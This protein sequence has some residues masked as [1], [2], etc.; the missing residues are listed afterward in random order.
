[1]GG[2]APINVRILIST[3]GA[4]QA[5]SAIR[6][7][8]ASAGLMGTN[9]NRGAIST[10][11]LG[12]AMRQ[13]ATLLKYTV[14]GAFMNVGRQ[15]VEL[16]RQFELTFSR[17]RGLVGFSAR[18]IEKFRQGVLS[19]A[20][21]TTRAPQE[22]AD[23]LYFVTSAGIKNTTT[24]LE[25]LESSAKAAASGLGETNVVADAVT[26][27]LN[28]YGSAAYDAAQ[29][30]DILVA[31]VREG[32]AEADTFAPAL[33]K[34]LPVAAAY[35]ASF[36]D[37]A[38]ATAALTRG[39]LSA[40]TSAI[41]IRQVLSQLMKPSKQARDA[42]LSVGTSTESIRKQV[43]EEGLLAALTTLN[44]K[45]DGSTEATAKVFGNVRALTAVLSL[46]GPNLSET[47]EI[48]ERMNNATGDLDYAFESYAQTADRQFN[49]AAAASQAA[50]IQF[51]DT[52]KPLVT[53]LLRVGEALAKVFGAIAGNKIVGPFIRFGGVAVLT[54][55]ALASILKTG[56][57]LVRLF[58]NM[59]IQLQA[60][61]TGVRGFTATIIQANAGTVAL[62]SNTAAATAV[63]QANQVT[64]AA[65]TAATQAGNLSTSTAIALKIQEI[66]ATAAA[67]NGG[68]LT[69]LQKM[70]IA[71]LTKAQNVA[72]TANNLTTQQGIL[73]TNQLTRSNYLSAGAM[74]I[75]ANAA[76]I[77][78]GAM[79]FLQASMGPIMLA[80]TVAT[81]VWS[82]WQAKKKDDI[83][84]TQQAG[85]NLEDLNEILQ[86]TIKWTRTGYSLDIEVDVKTEKVDKKVKEIEETLGSEFLDT[87]IGATG[88][89]TSKAQFGKAIYDTVFA[90]LTDETAREAALKVLSE[91]LAV[92][93]EDIVSA[94]LPGGTGDKV[95]DAYLVRFV[96]AFNSRA[97][98]TNIPTIDI[99]QGIFAGLQE[100]LAAGMEE[101]R[102]GRGS[103][104]TASLGAMGEAAA[105]AASKTGDL[106]P[107][108]LVMQQLSVSADAAGLT[109]SQTNDA[110]GAFT[111]DAL[112]GLSDKLDLAQDEGGNWAKVLADEQNRVKLAKGTYEQLGMS[113]EEAQAYYDGLAVKLKN[114]DKGTSGV[115]EANRIV[116]SEFLAHAK[117]VQKTNKQYAD[118]D[119]QLKETADQFLDGL[120]PAIQDL[121]DEWTAAEKAVKKYEEGQ[122]AV[123]GL[124]KST[125]E[126]NIDFRDSLRDVSDAASE[127]GGSLFTGSEE[128]DEAK[129]SIIEAGDSLL[130]LV[131]VIAAKGPEYR[132]EAIATLVAGQADILA[133][134]A[135]GGLDPAQV[136]TLFNEIGFDNTLIGTLQDAEE[137]AGQKSSEVGLAITTGLAT[138]LSAA[139]QKLRAAVVKQADTVLAQMR[140]VWGIESPSKTAAAEVG[141]P[142]ATGIAVGF[143]KETN[144]ARF[145]AAFGGKLAKQI[146]QALRKG[147]DRYGTFAK[148]A[149]GF[150][151]AKGDVKTPVQDFVTNQL[152]RIKEVIG[153]LGQYLRSQLDFRKAKDD[154]LKLANTQRLIDDN[155]K[156]ALR[157]ESAATRRFGSR[158][159]AEVT[160]YEQAQ[161]DE[162]QKAFERASRDYAM[163]RATLV[164]VVDA[165]IALQEARY[166]AAETN[167]T[168]IDAQNEVLD[169]DAAVRDRALE[170]AAAQVAVLESYADVQEASVQ[171]YWN[172]K[173]L[174]G[175]F[176]ALATAAGV[177]NLQLLEGGEVIAD[178]GI[179]FSDLLTQVGVD[180][181]NPEGEFLQ[182]LNGLGSEMWEAIKLGVR[183]SMAKSP[184]TAVGAGGKGV[185]GSG[186]GG[187]G[188]SPGTGFGTNEKQWK[189]DNRLRVLQELRKRYAGASIDN[190]S[191]VID[192]L[193]EPELNRQWL[194]SLKGTTG[195][196]RTDYGVTI[197]RKAV[198]GAVPGGVPTLVGERGPELFIPGKFGTVVAASALERYARV[199]GTTGAQA[200]AGTNNQFSI[201][202]YNPTPEPASDSIS[203][204]MKVLA[205]NGL[206]G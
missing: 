79:K 36:E 127:S 18:D 129:S 93:P 10:R 178:V 1:M 97:S 5:T 176:Q 44:T 30:T 167:E 64:V 125:V 102:V 164:E 40:G 158:G 155:R 193:L 29:V 169:A 98:G 39:G 170:L 120:N 80:L 9:L 88:D 160:D 142:I 75:S 2:T 175:V 82:I 24:A 91:N 154:L 96:E 135:R 204:R 186:K 117:S 84:T 62:A 181:T 35:G 146:S 198:G 6:Q 202:V 37:V 130:D 76:R 123:L 172:S 23:A 182:A 86:E 43:Q 53:D 114:V 183:E 191:A 203:R 136:Q 197:P 118:L 58:S 42:L 68:K 205:N 190:L 185:G 122:E 192:R 180:L 104:F 56:S 168:V 27:T 47:S 72:S 126:A 46:L 147:A 109:L 163:G 61:L 111:E 162:L 54:V 101:L 153:S 188:G 200:G 16:S 33:G 4:T 89:K 51:G 148:F 141:V 74:V 95:A 134:A 90:N 166:A 152:D 22:L 77:L 14:A 184:L 137:A 131:N 161:I 15:A 63:Q 195:S 189:A 173:E 194:E 100:S 110:I 21:E 159:G 59:G 34:V 113:V 112:Q 87:L 196:G 67:N 57:A 179:R 108:M 128:A 12:D 38:A 171:L 48:F 99:G 144:S 103:Q 41:Y 105:V 31:T 66:Q 49:A 174:P 3:A 119:V 124:S 85:K 139:D 19:L 25:I 138:G 116:S 13:T 107:L 69:I 115:A 71:T 149:Q 199:R 121:V 140:E 94:A 50:L 78:G 32:K 70:Q 55:A 106:T 145:K 157:A 92:N 187:S 52:L 151:K 83:E 143:N 177:T 65:M 8:T 11:T 206:F 150:T 132:D 45:F 60:T 17:I 73:L 165:E 28:A 20:G 201:N 7:V 133:A 156:K 81:T 26:S